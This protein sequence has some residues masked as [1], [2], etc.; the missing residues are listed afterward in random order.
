MTRRVSL[1]TTLLLLVACGDSSTNTPLTTSSTTSSST[2]TAGGDASSSVSGTGGGSTGTGGSSSTTGVGGMGG[3]GG[4]GGSIPEDPCLA[5]QPTC[6]TDVPAFAGGAMV[7]VDRCA[8]PLQEGA[9]W[10]SASAIVDE[11]AALLPA[12]PLSTILD[13]AN[14]TA[15]SVLSVPGSPSG[16]AGGFR[17]NDDD[18]DKPWW[19]PQGITTS[20][21]ASD[22]GLVAGRKVVAVSWYYDMASDPGSVAEKGVR[23]AM[24]DVSVNPPVYRLVLLVE[25]VAGAGGAPPTFQPVTIHAGGIA[26]YGDLLYVADTSK[27]LRVFDTSRALQVDTALDQIG[28]DAA[29]ATY[30]A[31]LYK[32][33]IPQVGNYDHTSLC[34]PRFS[35]VSLDRSTSPPSLVSGEYCNG[36]TACDKALSGRLFRYPLDAATGHLEKSLT[37]ASEAYYAA[38]TH[39]QGATSTAGKFFLSSSAPGG[40]AGAL[41]V[42]KSGAG[43]STFPWIDTPE[44]VSY[45]PLNAHLYGLS[46]GQGVRYVV[47]VNANAFP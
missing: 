38:Q 39:L 33:I 44:D 31:G 42:K 2:G 20:A 25:P 41:Y 18:N 19:I 46:E 27:G 37:F 11:L 6:P 5:V 34:D 3:S 14:R 8:F 40:S 45:D 9:V 30:Y 24:V 1:A 28:Y 13:D 15:I 23:L 10:S 32:Y 29:T 26:W 35:F 17:W 7:P 16:F 22:T 43:A 12:A 36:S 4:E 47:W 21:D